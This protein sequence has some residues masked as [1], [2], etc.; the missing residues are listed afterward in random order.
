MRLKYAG[1]YNVRCIMLRLEYAGGLHA[2]WRLKYAGFM[3]QKYIV[4]SM[5][6]Q[7]SVRCSFW[8][9]RYH[10]TETCVRWSIRYHRAEIRLRQVT[11]LWEEPIGVR[12]VRTL[13]EEPR[14]KAG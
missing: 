12:Q 13:S 3:M 1:T 8:Y 5:P 4:R 9:I 6:A 10:G 2:R 11:T 7:M 14:C